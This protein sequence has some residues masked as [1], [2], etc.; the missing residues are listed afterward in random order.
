MHRVTFAGGIVPKPDYVYRERYT[1]TTFKFYLSRYDR[2]GHPVYHGTVRN[3]RTTVLEFTDYRPSPMG[4]STPRD[5]ANDI[6]SFAT[7][8]VERPDD[9]GRAGVDRE[10]VCRAWWWHNGDT[11]SANTESRRVRA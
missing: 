1:R 10:Q 6:V 9:F 8:Y 11:L 2:Y 5:M 4:R 7:A 3:N